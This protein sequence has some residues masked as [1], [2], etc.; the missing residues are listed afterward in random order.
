MLLLEEARKGK[1]RLLL[2]MI[3]AMCLTSWIVDEVSVTV[4]KVQTRNIGSVDLDYIGMTG[5][6]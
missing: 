3:I 6:K 5:G 2:K 1:I 4:G